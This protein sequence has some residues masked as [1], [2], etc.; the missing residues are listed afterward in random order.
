MRK[1]TFIIPK[2]DNRG[3]RFPANVVQEIQRD[4]LKQFQGYTVKD[5]AGGWMDKEGKTYIDQSWE[6][7]VV[8]DEEGVARLKE[9][10]KKVKDLLSQEAMWLEVQET[11]SHLVV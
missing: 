2:T 5:A 7:T 9:W 1:A 11:E 8:T 3:N 4:I 10:L 6:Y